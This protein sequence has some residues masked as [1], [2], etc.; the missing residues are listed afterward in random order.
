MSEKETDKLLESNYDGIEEYDNDLPN[1]WLYLFYITIIFS[2]GYTA[3]YHF[4]PG[5]SPH[6]LL[7][8]QMAGLETV[9]EQVQQ[10]EPEA[11]DLTTLVG[12][13]E[14]IALGKGV[15]VTKCAA[16]HGA[17]GEG[18]IGPNLTDGFAIHGGT[19]SDIQ[20]VIENG[21]IEK[22]MLAW[23]GQLSSDE[24][25]GVIAYVWS[26]QNTHVAGKAPQGDPISDS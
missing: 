18:M 9:R 16:C 11:L 22:G 5:Q 14:R 15:F 13:S 23:K 24:M 21:V 19:L 25:I 3:Y 2:I 8:E 26:I 6:E 10:A 17:S 20:K 12:D 7:A 4:G 1:W